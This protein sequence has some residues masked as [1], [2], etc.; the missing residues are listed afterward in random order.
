MAIYSFSAVSHSRRSLLLAEAQDTGEFEN[1]LHA[2]AYLPIPTDGGDHSLFIFCYD[3]TENTAQGVMDT[4]SMS[5]HKSGLIRRAGPTPDSLS[6]LI[7]IER[8]IST[9]AVLRMSQFGDSR[10][11][12]RYFAERSGFEVVEG[13]ANMTVSL[14]CAQTPIGTDSPSSLTMAL[15]N[16][17][18]SLGLGAPI[19]SVLSCCIV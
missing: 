16:T 12:I 8:G 19:K 4:L 3:S 13:Q 2:A 17:C 9:E 5:Q 10:I 1:D 15:S 6:E 18:S 11:S 7:T 14:L